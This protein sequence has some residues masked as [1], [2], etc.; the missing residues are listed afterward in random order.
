MAI[1]Q[2]Q[3]RTVGVG[4]KRHRDAKEA[5]S[6]NHMAS[7]KALPKQVKAKIASMNLTRCA[8]NVYEAPST[9]DFWKVKGNDIVRLTKGSVVNN[10]EKIVAAPRENQQNFLDEILS[11]L[12]F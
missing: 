5:P 6:S 2:A 3:T 1:L 11:D 12:T 10:G 7:E 8:G 9:K 4:G